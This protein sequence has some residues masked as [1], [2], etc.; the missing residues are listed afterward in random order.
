MSI[1]SLFCY[2][3]GLISAFV[4]FTTCYPAGKKGGSLNRYPF[5]TEAPVWGSVVLLGLSVLG[6]CSV[7]VPV[8]AY[9]IGGYFLLFLSFLLLASGCCMIASF[10]FGF[11]KPVAHVRL[12]WLSFAFES[13][14]LAG[15]AFYFM[16]LDALYDSKVVGPLIGAISLVLAFA[17][18][19]PLLDRRTRNSFH[20]DVTISEDGLKEAKRP[21]FEALAF[22]ERLYPFLIGLGSLL[23]IIYVFGVA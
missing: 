18:L 10:Y 11:E 15:Q 22:Y 14:F 12:S 1:Y 16:S 5:E 20:M 13:C 8:V 19:V 6:F 17:S 7:F 21:K 3:V 9:G 4:L 23:S 2:I